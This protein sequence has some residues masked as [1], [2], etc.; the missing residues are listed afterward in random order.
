MNVKINGKQKSDG[1]ATG[2]QLVSDDRRL[3]KN[4]FLTNC[5]RVA[6]DEIFR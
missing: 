5:L 6:L 2:E 1:R 4:K 3:T